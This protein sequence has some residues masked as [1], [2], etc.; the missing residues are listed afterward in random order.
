MAA[1]QNVRS[2]VAETFEDALLRAKAEYLEMPGMQLTVTQAA[3]LWHVDRELCDAVLSA[4]VETRFLVKTRH[5]LFARA[6]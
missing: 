5:A 3:R 4:L 1:T 6:A 2:A